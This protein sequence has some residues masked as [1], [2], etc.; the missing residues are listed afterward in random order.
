[1][2]RKSSPI[3]CIL[4]IY[5]FHILVQLIQPCF[6]GLYV[7]KDTLLYLNSGIRLLGA[8]DSIYGPKRDTCFYD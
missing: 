8:S 3:F 1:M 7:H 2:K 4:N 6:E 5:P